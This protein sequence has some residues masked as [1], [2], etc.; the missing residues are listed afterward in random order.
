MKFDHDNISPLDSR[1]AN[2]ISELRENFSESA[3]IRIRF[4]IEIEWLLYIC[5]NLPKTFKPLSKQ[6]IKKNC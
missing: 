4:D 3:L 5:V 2:K 1:Y 6:S